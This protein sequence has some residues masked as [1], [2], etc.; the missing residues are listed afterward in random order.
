VRDPRRGEPARIARGSP[1][2]AACRTAHS[3]LV[4][5]A[6]GVCDSDQYLTDAADA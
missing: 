4:P 2:R 5:V 6:N 1:A 3:C